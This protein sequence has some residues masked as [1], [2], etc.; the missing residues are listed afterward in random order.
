[1]LCA[2]NMC[3]VDA[4]DSTVPIHTECMDVHRPCI[5]QRD[6][7]RPHATRTRV[8]RRD[9]ARDD[10][11]KC[12]CCARV[13]TLPSSGH[14]ARAVRESIVRGRDRRRARAKRFDAFSFEQQHYLSAHICTH[15]GARRCVHGCAHEVVLNIVF[16]RPNYRSPNMLYYCS[17]ATAVDSSSTRTPS[18]SRSPGEWDLRTKYTSMRPHPI[19]FHTTDQP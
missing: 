10:L 2:Y 13:L 16:V 8:D 15:G 17:S 6:T 4:K 18:T 11:H 14:T 5:G 7:I 9:N 3:A 12:V 1:M 19:P